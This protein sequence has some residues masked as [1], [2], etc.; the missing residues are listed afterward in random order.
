M[1]SVCSFLRKSLKCQSS[2]LQC[3]SFTMFSTKT[4]IHLSANANNPNVNHI[5]PT[6]RITEM[7]CIVQFLLQE[8]VQFRI[9]VLISQLL[10]SNTIR[11]KNVTANTSKCIKTRIRYVRTTSD[12]ANHNEGTSKE[13]LL[14]F[15]FC[16]FMGNCG[17]FA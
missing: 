9:R 16:K 3:F 15:S 6:F 2:N 17:I 4:T 5:S 12:I 7:W 14:K 11:I 13:W 1:I 8:Q 10:L